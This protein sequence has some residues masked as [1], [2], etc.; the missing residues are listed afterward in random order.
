[1]FE[2]HLRHAQV[3]RGICGQAAE[4]EEAFVVQ[5]VSRETNYLSC[6]AE[7]KAE[8]VLP[9]FKAGAG[10]GRIVGELDIDSHALAPFSDEDRQSLEKVCE[11][12]A[13]VF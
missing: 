4:R 2:D 8:I 7:V 6:S 5:G 11:L 12:A 13:S 3:G 9:I 10:G 1:V